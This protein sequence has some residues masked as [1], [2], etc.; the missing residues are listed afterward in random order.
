MQV[1]EKSPVA[2]ERPPV[3]ACSDFFSPK[4]A[5]IH[6]G[7][8]TFEYY[9]K[10]NRWKCRHWID[11]VNSSTLTRGLTNCDF[12]AYFVCDD[13][14]VFRNRCASRYGSEKPEKRKEVTPYRT[15]CFQLYSLHRPTGPL[16]G[17]V[18]LPLCCRYHQ[19][20]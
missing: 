4:R 15:T 11:G 6:V 2:S 13:N 14:F 20:P 1:A 17:S 16:L 5:Q 19:R 10:H 18:R 9:C 7:R 3:P 12:T 8:T